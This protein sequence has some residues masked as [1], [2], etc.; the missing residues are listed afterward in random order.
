MKKIITYI[1]FEPILFV[2]LLLSSFSI[3]MLFVRL[4]VSHS[5]YLFFLIWNLILAFIPYLISIYLTYKIKIREHRFLRIFSFIIWLLFLPNSFYILTD[6]KHLYRESTIP[7]WYDLLTISV[8]AITGFFA[9]LFSTLQMQ[10]LIQIHY[11]KES[12]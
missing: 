9:G 12:V 3:L 2:L 4:K 6:F 1:K 5:I 10:Q 8:F 11:S 7:F